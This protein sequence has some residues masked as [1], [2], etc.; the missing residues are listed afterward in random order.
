M[1]KKLSTFSFAA[2]FII[3]LQSC[4]NYGDS[5]LYFNKNA[6]IP[7]V[8][9]ILYFNPEIFPDVT[10]IKEPTYAAFYTAT[11]D[12]MKSFGNTKYM[13]VDTSISFDEVDEN[14][15]REICKNN[16]AD[17]AVIPKVKYFK[18]GFG[19]YVFSNQVVVSMKLYNAQ[20]EFILETAYDT[21]K[22]NGRMLGSAENSVIIGTKG[23][24]RKIEKEIKNHQI[25]DHKSS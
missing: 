23:A 9:T 10:E 5:L 12:K 24:I 14:M 11:S 6:K 7:K 21:Y 3:V 8:K 17:I 16:N 13:Q 19:K 22:G 1:N 18:V 20:G 15:V 2:M 25:L 4:A